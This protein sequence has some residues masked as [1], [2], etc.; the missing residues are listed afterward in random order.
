MKLP[1]SRRELLLK[2]GHGFGGIALAG[3]ME[4]ENEGA[5][6]TK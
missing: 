4:A 5:Q 1:Y 2:A 6:L 3:L